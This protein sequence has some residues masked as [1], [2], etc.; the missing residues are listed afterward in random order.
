[1]AN[2]AKTRAEDKEF[3]FLR[4]K[5]EKEL[6]LKQFEFI[7]CDELEEPRLGHDEG[8]EIFVIGSSPNDVMQRVFLTKLD[9]RGNMKQ[10][11]VVELINE[12][13]DKLDKDPL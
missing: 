1:M 12:F 4:D 3:V 5:G 2:E 11:R 8:K 9:V 7:V 13:G 10:D 6:I